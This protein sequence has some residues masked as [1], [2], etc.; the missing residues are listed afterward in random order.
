[1]PEIVTNKIKNVVVRPNNT[2]ETIAKI[3][4][5]NNVLTIGVIKTEE[6]GMV[7]IKDHHVGD[8]TILIVIVV[9][10]VHG[11]N[12]NIITIKIIT[13]IKMVGI[14]MEEVDI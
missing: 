5:N 4:I 2:I 9:T 1:M 14:I 10:G 7:I 13:D 8:I 12:G 6:D 11:V 3:I